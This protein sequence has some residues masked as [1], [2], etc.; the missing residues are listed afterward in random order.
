VARGAPPGE[1]GKTPVPPPDAPADGP[2]PERPDW[3]LRAGNLRELERDAA[4]CS[5]CPLCRARKGFLF[6]RGLDQR[7]ALMFVVGP[8]GRAAV[9]EG[10]FPP[11]KEGELLS[12]LIER[13]F[14]VDAGR[15]YVTPAVKCAADFAGAVSAR[16][17]QCCGYIARRQAELLAPG[18][19]VALGEDAGRVMAGR[20]LPVG[21]LRRLKRL[22]LPS[23]KGKAPLWITYGLDHM[24]AADAVKTEAWNDLRP[25][26][27][28]R[29]KG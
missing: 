4:K 28:R 2:V 26:A 6:G 15:V 24:L 9:R 20:D 21:I 29:L 11:G 27:S 1:A 18:A 17:R 19:V 8:Q 23:G 12:A 22:E 16:A 25:L 10:A 5:L 3:I 7:P 14:K 13:G